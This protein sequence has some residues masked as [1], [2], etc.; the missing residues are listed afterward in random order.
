MRKKPTFLQNDVDFIHLDFH[1]LPNEN[2]QRGINT[3]D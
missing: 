2:H 1:L 3:E